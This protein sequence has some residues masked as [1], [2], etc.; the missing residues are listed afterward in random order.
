V[1]VVISRAAAEA[2]FSAR[3]PEV[4][5]AYRSNWLRGYMDAPEFRGNAPDSEAHKWYTMGVK[6]RIALA[7][8]AVPPPAGPGMTDAALLRAAIEASGLS[9]RQYAVT[10]LLRDERTVRR[11]LAGDSPI[12]A[13]VR[14]F[15]EGQPPAAPPH[16][17]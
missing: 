3:Y 9:A 1:T 16:V 6:A 12:P 2:L 7:R 5:G 17:A 4:F 14:Q 11:W 8:Q 15:L 13:P 10:V